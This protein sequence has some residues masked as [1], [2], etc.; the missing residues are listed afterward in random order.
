MS[1][2]RVL[3]GLHEIRKPERIG[4]REVVLM[5]TDNPPSPCLSIYLGSLAA[6]AIGIR[7]ANNRVQL[8]IGKGEDAGRVGIKNAGV[9]EGDFRC[10]AHNWGAHRVYLTSQVSVEHFTFAPRTTIPASQIEV[11][12][13]M[14]VFAYSGLKA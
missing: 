11:R 13:Q 1:F 4:E 8:F 6:H 10:L 14:L 2:E 9:G 7:S 3:R 5:W 12:G